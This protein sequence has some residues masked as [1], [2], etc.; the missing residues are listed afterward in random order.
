MQPTLCVNVLMYF[1][2]L[3]PRLEAPTSGRGEKVCR[4]VLRELRGKKCIIAS[5]L[6][7]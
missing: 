2:L 5:L 1:V 3:A 6:A 7:C 4:E